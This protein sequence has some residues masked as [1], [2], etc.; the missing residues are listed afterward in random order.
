MRK[1]QA[2]YEIII[3]TLT[4]S[5]L[6]LSWDTDYDVFYLII[7]VYFIFFI[8]VVFRFLLAKNKKKWL[9]NNYLDII[10][11]IPFD[12]LFQLAR[13]PRLLKILKITNII[14]RY[15]SSFTNFI[16]DNGLKKIFTLTFVN[17]LISAIPLT[18]FENDITSYSDGVWLAVVTVTTI[19]Y[20]DLVPTSFFGRLAA[21]YLMLFGIGLVGI[22]TASTATY[23]LKKDN[24]SSKKY[25]KNQIDHLESMSDKEI[26][27]IIQLIISYKKS[28]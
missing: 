15:F 3:L 22:L 4:L 26:E 12:P 11:I 6:Y 2:I 25:L 28:N 18:I 7:A 8:D 19:G 27:S 14:N 9:I 17:I 13:V 23:F 1:I 20:G 24:D 5:S 21:M 10:T 16:I